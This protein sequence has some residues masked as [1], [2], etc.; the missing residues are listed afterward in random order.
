MDVEVEVELGALLLYTEEGPARKPAGGPVI[1]GAAAIRGA[2]GVTAEI[3]KSVKGNGLDIC[4][5]PKGPTE[6]DA[7]GPA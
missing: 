3:E 1:R 5:A 7:G 2:A 4:C 6:D